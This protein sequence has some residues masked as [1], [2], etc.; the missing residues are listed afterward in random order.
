M[1]LVGTGH[2]DRVSSTAES[3]AFTTTKDIRPA[4]RTVKAAFSVPTTAS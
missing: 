4:Q 1:R 3:R 2:Q